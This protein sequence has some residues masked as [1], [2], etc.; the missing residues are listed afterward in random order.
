MKKDAELAQ[1]PMTLAELRLRAVRVFADTSVASAVARRKQIVYGTAVNDLEPQSGLDSEIIAQAQD[2]VHIIKHGVFG[3]MPSAHQL[4]A[5]ERCI[6][7]M[8]PVLFVRHAK[9]EVPDEEVAKVP[10]SGEQRAAIEQFLPGVAAISLTQS[11]SPAAT[12]FLVAP[13]ILV[14]NRHVA[15][16]LAGRPHDPT[17]SLAAGLA[18]AHF[19]WEA[20]VATNGPRIPIGRVLVYPQDDTVDLAFLELTADG[21]LPAGLPLARRSDVE[22]GQ[23]VLVVGYPEDDDRSPA[24]SKAMFGGVFGVKRAA[25]GELVGVA[26]GRCYHDC[27][28]LGG[29]S[30]SP[31]FDCRTGLV[32]AV[33]QGGEFA[34]RNEAVPT[35]SIA[36]DQTLASQVKTWRESP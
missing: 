1:V 20:D 2:A 23:S 15:Q 36:A 6:R 7:F 4:N 12:G 19:G 24:W 29:N 31:I 26:P 14:T 22:V 34:Y 30:G 3:V 18:V 32:I 11:S 21:P 28:T 9:I 10:L 27:S 35:S 8:R 13:R 17:P 25:P 5:L 33:H 16:I